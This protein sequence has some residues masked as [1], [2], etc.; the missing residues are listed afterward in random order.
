MLRWDCNKKHRD[1]LMMT[2]KC[3]KEI[4]KKIIV[5]ICNWVDLVVLYSMWSSWLQNNVRKNKRY[6]L[7]CNWLSWWVQSTENGAWHVVSSIQ[8]FYHI[9]Y[10][11]NHRYHPV[12]D[13]KQHKQTNNKIIHLQ[14]ISSLGVQHLKVLKCMLLCI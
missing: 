8:S 11:Y 10:H 6:S 2:N 4:K 1:D 7:F 3:L 12:L 13:I 5:N 9:H 14:K